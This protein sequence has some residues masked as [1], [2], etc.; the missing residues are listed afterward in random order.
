MSGI[1]TIAHA[2]GIIIRLNDDES[3]LHVSCTVVNKVQMRYG[4]RAGNF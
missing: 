4:N 1:F 2:T 3:D